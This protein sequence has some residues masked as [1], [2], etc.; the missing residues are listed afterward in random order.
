MHL[1]VC[2]IGLT[3]GKKQRIIFAGIYELNLATYLP[4][5]LLTKGWTLK[6]S[7]SSICSPVPMNMIGLRVAATLKHTNVFSLL[8]MLI[9]IY[10]KLPT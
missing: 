9:R 4:S 3:I 2:I 10:E 7:K 6:G 8:F 1:F 5:S